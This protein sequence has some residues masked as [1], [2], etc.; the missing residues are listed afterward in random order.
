MKI[1]RRRYRVVIAPNSKYRAERFQLIQSSELL[2]IL[3][4]Y[5]DIFCM[6]INV[7]NNFLYL[8]MKFDKKWVYPIIAYRTILLLENISPRYTLWSKKSTLVYVFIKRTL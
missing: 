7:D 3:G 8:K 6:H 4:Y 1:N 5:A 2:K